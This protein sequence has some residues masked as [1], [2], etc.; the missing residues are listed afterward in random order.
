MFWS[1]LLTYTVC[2]FY[3]V[4]EHCSSFIASQ[5]RLRQELKVCFA[6]AVQLISLYNPASKGS[7]SVA[8]ADFL[9]YKAPVLTDKIKWTFCSMHALIVL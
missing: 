5:G 1:L 2:T 6:P 3:R 7:K 4:V 9:C 8:G